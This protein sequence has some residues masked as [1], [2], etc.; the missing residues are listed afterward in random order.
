[1][2]PFKLQLESIKSHVYHFLKWESIL[3]IYPLRSKYF[4]QCN[5]K[6]KQVLSPHFEELARKVIL[7]VTSH[8]LKIQYELK[9]TITQTFQPLSVC[10]WSVRLEFKCC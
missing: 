6:N 2:I 10:G 7:Q 1:M 4:D 8:Q 3:C 5:G 9:N